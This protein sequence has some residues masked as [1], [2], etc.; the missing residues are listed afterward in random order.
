MGGEPYVESGNCL[1]DELNVYWN[2][3]LVVI[4]RGRGRQW[5]FRDSAAPRCQW[6]TS[7]DPGPGGLLVEG[8]L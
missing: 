6:G 5:E 4:R 8:W 3:R 2:I 1:I 7:T